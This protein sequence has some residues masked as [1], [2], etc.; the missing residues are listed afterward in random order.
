[1][2]E[3]VLTP[4]DFT[5]EIEN[6]KRRNNELFLELEIATRKYADVI[7]ILEDIEECESHVLKSTKQV[8]V[9][10]FLSRV[11]DMDYSNGYIAVEAIT[12]YEKRKERASFVS[13]ILKM[14][15]RRNKN[16]KN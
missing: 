16:G 1:M 12:Y 15:E 14:L 2:N 8:S 10:D 13:D 5:T 7:S 3:T 9:A 11:K 4:K 6:L